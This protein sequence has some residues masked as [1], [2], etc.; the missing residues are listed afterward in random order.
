MNESQMRPFPEKIHIPDWNTFV[1]K[2]NETDISVIDMLDNTNPDAKDEF[3]TDKGLSKPKNE[4]G[5][6]DIKRVEQNIKTIISLK[7]ELELSEIPEKRRVLAARIL[8]DN[9]KKNRFVHASYLYNHASHDG[10]A[11]AAEEH[12]KANIALY[13]EPDEDVFWSILAEKLSSIP[14]ENLQGEDKIMYSEVLEMIGPL[15]GA[16]CRIFRPQKETVEWFSDAIEIFFEGFLA[17]IPEG[18]QEFSIE[19]ACVVTNEIIRSEFGQDAAAG[20]CAGD[21]YAGTYAG[22]C[23]GD[24][25]AG[26]DADIMAK[27]ADRAASLDTTGWKAVVIPS[28]AVAS[29][30]C[31]Q[32][33]IRFPGKRSRG[34]YT[35]KELKA[36]I[37]HELGV[38]ALRSLPYES[39]GIKSFSLGIPGY[40]AF[41][42]GVAKAAEQAVNRQYEDSGLLHYISIGLAYFLGKN[43]REVFEIQRRLE[44]LTKG[45]PA[46]RC[47]DSV[48][49]TFRGTSELP[50]HKDLI[51]YNGANQV[52]KYIEEHLND[53][54][55]MEQLFLNGKTS[56]INKAHE[57]MVYEMRT[58]GY[59]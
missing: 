10:R 50:N 2:M 8:D 42:E 33:L 29:T 30:D 51:Y 43:F 26:T 13:G 57:R 17:H 19:E 22:T 23:T 4:Y 37:I 53:A 48:Q 5:K 52:W 18:Q 54:E 35:R 11:E 9:L 46:G 38:H 47:F 27:D 15:R 40:E 44:H 3:L 31:E 16:D 1:K 32:K 58:G 34:A 20:T 7:K 59:L 6:L 14:A 36:I 25:C 21:T 24:T 39:C 45:E 55:L 56:M 41:E 12:R 28:G 49:R